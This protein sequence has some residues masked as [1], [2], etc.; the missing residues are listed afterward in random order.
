MAT[1][2][3][4]TLHAS[5]PLLRKRSV[6]FKVGPKQQERRLGHLLKLFSKKEE[7]T[8]RLVLKNPKSGK[9]I[10]MTATV[11]ED[12][13]DVLVRCEIAAYVVLLENDA[14]RCAHVHEEVLPRLIDFS[15][16]TTAAVDGTNSEVLHSS[17]EKF[18][19]SLTP[20]YARSCRVGQLGCACS[21][22]ALWSRIARETRELTLV[23]E[24]DVVLVESFSQ[25]LDDVLDDIDG[26]WDILYLFHHPECQPPD[27]VTRSRLV[28]NGFPTW[29]TVA[30][31]L[32]RSGAQ[33]LLH[34]LAN[35][36]HDKAI[37]LK[38]MDLVREREI[39]T[40]VA[41][42]PLCATAGLMNPTHSAHLTKL[43]TTVW[44][45]PRLLDSF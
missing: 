17:L 30:Y 34:R 35:T 38:I 45:S 1:T 32:S 33:K 11:D 20:Q 37:D 19:I 10:P 3:V 22:I 43:G 40:F 4:V 13:R 42:P 27:L 41:M 2:F 21:H 39:T 24:D 15:A 6:R 29:G 31:V 23:L 25:R 12:I 36:A 44:D 9:R 5:G 14:K 28:V 26:T 8:L 7:D 16:S 18:N